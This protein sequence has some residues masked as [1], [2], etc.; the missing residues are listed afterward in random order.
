LWTFNPNC[1]LKKLHK[2]VTKSFIG[3]LI[4]TFFISIFLLLMQF[5]WKYINDLVGKG[6]DW[7]VIAELLLYASVTLVPMGL[8]L[9]ILLASIMTFG[10]LGES[11]ELFAIK[12]SG[13]SLY[14]IMRP[15][16]FLVVFI[17]IGAFYFSNNLLPYTNLKMRTLLHDV[18][19]QNPEISIQEGIFTSTIED[20]SIKVDEKDKKT[21]E[22]KN[23]LVYD[24]RTP[25]KPATVIIAESGK[26]SMTSDKSYMIMKLKNGHLYDE[27][28][29]NKPKVQRRYPYQRTDFKEQTIYIKMDGLGLKRSDETLFKD[30]YQMLSLSQLTDAIDSLAYDVVRRK[31]VIGTN[32][33]KYSLFKGIRSYN[34][35]E[36]RNL[37][38]HTKT[39]T[40][41]DG[42]T[43]TEII[44]EKPRAPFGGLSS[45]DDKETDKTKEDHSENNIDEP[46]KKKEDEYTTL[47]PFPGFDTIP[48]E[49]IITIDID[50][51]IGSF[52]VWNKNKVVDVALNYA[53]SSQT[54]I[55]YASREIDG[56]RRWVTRHEIEWH[57]KFVLS[58]SC[59]VLF[60]IGAPLGAI[61][62]KG[63]IGMPTV[64]SVV[65][66]VLYFIITM[67]SE[68]MVREAILPP[69]IGMWI[70]TF[71]L[72]PIGIFLTIKAANDSM[73]MRP[74]SYEKLKQALRI[75][76]RRKRNRKNAKR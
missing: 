71:I 25:Q 26:L 16:V 46:Q 4:I 2:Y 56:N 54:Y 49:T 42:E 55:Y 39:V 19:Q 10:N 76:R 70:S 14:R 8:P 60:F 32:I 65:F 45:K 57:K 73:N 58:I 67:F 3:P 20:I 6:L 11:Y 59:L 44:K 68:K 5:L 48:K 53:R 24:H 41:S 28:D 17:S 31:H 22:L 13:I 27:I 50:S 23:V 52:D 18:Q 69:E 38:Q 51:L 74:E 35:N 61:I 9:A 72:L 63:G 75:K 36:N 12:S 7:N 21:N 64:V 34:N 62:R 29:E 40:T 43:K 30:N 37:V 1:V 47:F 66:F 33:M 15:L